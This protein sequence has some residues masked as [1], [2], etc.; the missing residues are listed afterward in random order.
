MAAL[1]ADL[2][3]AVAASFGVAVAD[4]EGV[5]EDLL[6]RADDAMYAAKGAGDALRIAA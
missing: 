3:I 4:G 1:A 2:G 5:G 6:R